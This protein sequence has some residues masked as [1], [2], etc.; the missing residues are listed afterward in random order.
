M[1]RLSCAGLLAAVVWQSA[2][3][4]SD[5]AGS[6]DFVRHAADAYWEVYLQRYPTFAT[7]IGEHRWDH[8]LEDLG[9]PARQQW[10]NTVRQFLE[11]VRSVPAD[12]LPEADR[13]NRTVLERVM[14]DEL[15]RVDSPQNLMPL[16]PLYG[17]HL[18]LPLL[19]VS[20]PLND[21]GDF[22]A[23]VARLLEFPRQVDELIAAMRRGWESGIVA[24]LPI[25]E[26]VLVQLR[27]Q[28][29]DDPE[30]CELYAAKEVQRLPEPERE[31]AQSAIRVAVSAHVVPAYRRLLAFVDE[32]YR[33]RARQTVGLSTL[34]GGAAWYERLVRRHTTLPLS[35]DDVHE[36]GL[37]E[38]A[39]LRQEMSAVQQ[40]VGFEGTLDQFQ[41]HM[42]T[43]PRHRFDSADALYTAADEILQRT[44]PRLS[45]L[46]GRLPRADCVMRR[47]ESFRAPAAPVAYYNA[48]APDGSRPGYYY[49]NTY[50]PG[51]RLRFTLEALTYH[52]AVPGHH[53]QFALDQENTELPA[54]RRHASFTAY[55]EG[56]ALY[57]EKLGYEIGGYSE[58]SD[59]YGQLTFEMW[60]ACRLVVD[61]G[62]HHK[63]WSRSEAI[64]F[65]AGNTSLAPLDIEAEVD[66]YITWP[67]Q[68]LAYKV[69]EL[70]ILDLRARARRRLGDRFDLRAFHDALLAGGAMPLD[71]LE[72][73]METWM[74]GQL[75]PP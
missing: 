73:R 60:R 23:Y 53:L 55:V 71:L 33:P 49:I 25:V 42:R 43:D 31:E 75:A 12:H 17:A 5:P 16:D 56:W 61:T 29:V 4:A 47:I 27:L 66:R 39:R 45:S 67:G 30:K 28:A 37:R 40:Q 32:E 46:F 44:K 1:T 34:P 6:T 54:Y 50:E 38:V 18:R 36:L 10:L 7:A 41:A 14:L 65:M 64:N 3:F 59:R 69:G 63:G 52:E 24:P 70:H 11:R 8:K 72:A 48:A 13:L 21:A 22:R 35:A 2:G 20:Q 9:E 19:L 68:A 57:A 62:L 26:K 15:D 51:E 58:P 74:E